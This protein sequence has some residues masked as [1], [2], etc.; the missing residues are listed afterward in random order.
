MVSETC[1]GP[2]PAPSLAG[3]WDVAFWGELTMHVCL[4]QTPRSDGFAQCRHGGSPGMRCA[5]PML[6]VPA[7][8]C[9]CSCQV[10]AAETHPWLSAAACILAAAGVCCKTPACPC[11]FY[12]SVVRDVALLRCRCH[13]SK[14]VQSKC[15]LERGLGLPTQMPWGCPRTS[16]LPAHLLAGWGGRAEGWWPHWR[17]HCCF[18]PSH[19]GL[20]PFFANCLPVPRC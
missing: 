15:W 9:S 18:A 16:G 8:P 13:L 1:P 6:A 19:E 10:T 3:Q 20:V 12:P 7:A 17:Q 11:G 5:A 2:C 4:G 14:P